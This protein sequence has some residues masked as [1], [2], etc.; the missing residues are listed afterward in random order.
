MIREVE[1]ELAL[2]TRVYPQWVEAGRLKAAV[3]VEQ[4][5]RI[6]A[7]LDLLRERE[8]RLAEEAYLQSRQ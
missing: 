2:R 4:T 3:A 7:V 5:R 1:R 6:K 8:G